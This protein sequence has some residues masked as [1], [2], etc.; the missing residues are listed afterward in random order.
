L[1]QQENGAEISLI[2]GDR[3]KRVKTDGPF[4]TVKR[5]RVETVRQSIKVD[6]NEPPGVTITVIW[7]NGTV[8]HFIPAGLEKLH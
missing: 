4:G 1:E 3:V 5:I 7:D 6:S 8:S 2:K